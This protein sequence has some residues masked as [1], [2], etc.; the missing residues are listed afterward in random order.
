MIMKHYARIRN[1]LIISLLIAGNLM[2]VGHVSAHLN[3]NV[4]GCEWCLSQGHTPAVPLPAEI[5]V[6]ALP[7]QAHLVA[8]QAT[9]SVVAPVF[10]LYRSRAPPKFS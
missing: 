8:D 4:A 1:L 10:N 5:S 9:M 6:S 3:P 7:L 2:F